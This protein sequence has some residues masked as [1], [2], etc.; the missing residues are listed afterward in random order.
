MW[1]RKYLSIWVLLFLI[2]MAMAIYSTH[3]SNRGRLSPFEQFVYTVS[4]PVQW[5]LTTIIG[6]FRS[7]WQ[8]YFY[9]VNVQQE[10]RILRKRVQQMEQQMTDY[11]ELRM[12]NVRLSR[13]LDFKSRFERSTIAAQ[14]IG[15]DSTGW[16]Q[17]L[18]LDK[19]QSHGLERG[20]PVVAPNGILGQTIE[21]ARG[22]SKVLLIIDRNSAVAVMIQRS[23]SRGILEGMGK[24]GKRNPCLMKLCLMKYVA[25][26]ADVQVGD[27]VITSGLGGIYPKGLLV[28]T[29]TSVRPKDSGQFQNVEVEPSVDFDR[30]EEVQVVLTDRT[31]RNER[32]RPHETSG[33]AAAVKD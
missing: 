4:R 15:D 3:R 6:G 8:D 11:Q 32:I 20:L 24:R 5:T 23:R 17:T 9:L 27:R 21:C 22:T 30:L 19:G 26:T 10:N 7:L 12:F 31:R 29:V 16:F 28:G 14:V 33:R 13:L 1:F 18:L 2:L 25:R